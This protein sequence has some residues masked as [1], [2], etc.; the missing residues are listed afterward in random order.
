MYKQN[1]QA[2]SQKKMKKGGG[3]QSYKINSNPYVYKSFY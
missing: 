1:K 3:G 2:C